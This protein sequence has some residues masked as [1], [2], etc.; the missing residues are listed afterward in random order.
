MLPGRAP[1][2]KPKSL[3]IVFFRDMSALSMVRRTNTRRKSSHTNMFRRAND[4]LAAPDVGKSEHD[5]SVE[6]FQHPRRI[7]RI[8]ATLSAAAG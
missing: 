4:P 7:F 1:G 3:G 6:H 5:E 2:V 8:I